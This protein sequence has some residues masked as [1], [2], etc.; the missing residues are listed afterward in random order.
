MAYLARISVD[1]FL[2]IL[3]FS[4]APRIKDHFAELHLYRRGFKSWQT[5]WLTHDLTGVLVNHAEASYN[6]RSQIKRA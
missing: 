6:I 4:G 3:A 1:L 5:R 2:A